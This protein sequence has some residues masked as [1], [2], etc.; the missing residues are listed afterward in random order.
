MATDEDLEQRKMFAA[1][2]GRLKD[3]QLRV[4]LQG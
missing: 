1:Y 4:T 3:A 2:T